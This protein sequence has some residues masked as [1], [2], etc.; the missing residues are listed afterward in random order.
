M[1][2]L[3]IIGTCL[4][5]VLLPLIGSACTNTYDSGVN[6]TTL[7]SFKIEKNKTTEQELIDHFGQPATVES[8]SDGSQTL[9]WSGATSETHNLGYLEGFTMALGV[10]HEN[11]NAHTTALS[12]T[13]RNGI[14]VDYKLITSNQQTHLY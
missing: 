1:R 4:V 6:P 5:A 7:E 3:N 11:V 13:V 8:G 9:T 12:V 2:R 14:V 10:S